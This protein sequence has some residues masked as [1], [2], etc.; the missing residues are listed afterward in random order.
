MRKRDAGSAPKL[1]DRVPYVI[2]AKGAKTPAFEKAEDPL[3]VLREKIPIDT[4]YYM[5][6]QLLKPLCRLFDPLTNNQA[7]I[8]FTRKF[9]NLNSSLLISDFRRRTCSSS[10]SNRQQ[11]YGNGTVCGEEGNLHLVQM[12]TARRQSGAGLSKLRS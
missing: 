11:K 12:H 5:Q 1:G 3:Y 9:G 8:I 10:H 6:N 4:N 2:V 7:E